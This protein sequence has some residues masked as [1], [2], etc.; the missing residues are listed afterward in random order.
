MDP[1][2][3]V[4]LFNG[5]FEKVRS[6]TSTPPPPPPSLL[7]SLYSSIFPSAPPPPPQ[8][9]WEQCVEL[10]TPSRSFW[11]GI[12]TFA[13]MTLILLVLLLVLILACSLIL[14]CFQVVKCHRSLIFILQRSESRVT[15]SFRPDYLVSELIFAIQRIYG[16]WILSYASI[17]RYCG[18][19]LVSVT[20]H[21]VAEPHSFRCVVCSE[22]FTFPSPSYPSLFDAELR[23]H[24]HSL[25][26]SVCGVCGVE[27]SIP[28]IA[29]RLGDFSKA[30]DHVM[31]HFRGCSKVNIYLP[32]T[33]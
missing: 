29:A 1:M 32:L 7:G 5:F 22:D 25:E 20:Q 17:C 15:T 26:H 31:E 27:F 2:G 21:Q 14:R 3:W 19:K 33:M 16:D 30:L 8:S 28:L 9:T 12:L 23:F 24:R 18:K 10:I 6:L 11:E 4:R 13:F